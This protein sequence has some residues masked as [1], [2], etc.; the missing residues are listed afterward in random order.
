MTESTEKYLLHQTGPINLCED[1][2]RAS[3]RNVVDSR[4]FN[5]ILA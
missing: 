2:D 3:L 1:R 4:M 5:F